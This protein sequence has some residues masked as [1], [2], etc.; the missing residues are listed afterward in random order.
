[1]KFIIIII[2]LLFYKLSICQITDTSKTI[3]SLNFNFNNRYSYT[4]NHLNSI[5]GVKFGFTLFKKHKVGI[6]ANYLFSKSYDYKIINN[7]NI[8]YEIRTP[9]KYYYFSIFYEPILYK[10]KHWEFSI[11]FQLG[12]GESYFYYWLDNQRMTY[13]KSSLI[14]IESVLSSHYK[15]YWW[16]G[17]GSGLGYNYHLKSNALIENKFNGIVFYTKIKIFVGDIYRCYKIKNVDE[18]NSK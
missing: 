2:L 15:I 12:I 5:L 3:S 10:D 11:P 4:Q 14:N 7:N 13:N 6:G 1:M 8:S 16:I 18:N 9:L 17:I